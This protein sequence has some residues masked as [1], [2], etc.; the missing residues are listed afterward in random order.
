MQESALLVV[1][2]SST[3]RLRSS[4]KHIVRFSKIGDMK[5]KPRVLIFSGYGLHTEDETKDAFERAGAAADIVHLNDLIARP[6]MLAKYQIVCIGGGFA[7]GDHTGGGKAYGNR[8]R[9]HLG[10]ALE[11]FLS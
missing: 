3:S 4:P 5:N 8:V 1:A 7:Y 10:E 11:R 2:R 9:N 6:S